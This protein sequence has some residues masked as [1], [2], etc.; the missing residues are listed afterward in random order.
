AAGDRTQHLRAAREP[1]PG[2]PVR[3]V[4]SAAGDG[5]ARRVRAAA[6]AAACRLGVRLAAGADRHLPD[7]P[8]RTVRAATGLDARAAATAGGTLVR[9]ARLLPDRAPSADA[10]L[11][12]RVLVDAGHE[13]GPPAVRG[14][15]Q[16][17]YR[18]RGEVPGR[19]RP[20]RDARRDVSPVPAPGADA[21][22]A[23]A[24]PSLR[25]RRAGA[26]RASM[27][28]SNHAPVARRRRAAAAA[29]KPPRT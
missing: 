2:R 8:F 27:T 28:G 3:V 9:G 22:A 20:G 21:A 4:A 26:A 5:L 19:A 16:R 17:V 24:A 13:P 7:Q 25:R 18:G 1:V 12:A 15:H 23:A 10:W 11:H 29:G 14:G 6:L